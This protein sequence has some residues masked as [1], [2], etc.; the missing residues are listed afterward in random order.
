MPSGSDLFG[1]IAVDSKY[2]TQAQLEQALKDQEALLVLGVRK[3]LGEILKEKGLLTDKQIEVILQEQRFTEGRQ[4]ARGYGRLAVKNGFITEAELRDTLAEQRTLFAQKK[5]MLPLG[6]L[7]VRKGI[8]TEQQN[9]T[10]LRQQNRIEEKEPEV[11]KQSPVLYGVRE[12][13]VCAALSPFQAESCTSCGA[14]LGERAGPGACKSCGAQ[15]ERSSEFCEKCG[16]NVLTGTSSKGS[17]VHPC[18]GCGTPLP[19]GQELCLECVAKLPKPLAKRMAGSAAATALYTAKLVAALAVIVA[20][21]LVVLIVIDK[22]ADA[23]NLMRSMLYGK[24]SA[25]LIGRAEQFAEHLARLQYAALLAMSIDDTGGKT[26]PADGLRRGQD[27][28]RLA[29]AG[30]DLEADLVQYVVTEHGVTGESGTTTMDL[31]FSKTQKLPGLNI[32]TDSGGNSR[33]VVA[34]GAKL[35]TLHIIWNWTYSGEE[36]FFHAAK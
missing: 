30:S 35:S 18:G 26:N 17:V 1:V 3:R 12:C 16:A 33:M 13:P 28:R 8:L 11:A 34:P 14:F 22:G 10:V 27:L 7:F 2:V 25:R 15:Q 9:R 20:V 6:A 4:E 19:H 31:T 32:R 23:K 5:E 36:W 21:P 29:V 24:K